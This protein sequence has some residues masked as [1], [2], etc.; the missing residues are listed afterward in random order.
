MLGLQK[1]VSLVLNSVMLNS[2][3]MQHNC[4]ARFKE[5]GWVILA[6]LNGMLG[7]KDEINLVLHSVMVSSRKMCK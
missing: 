5:L 7:L 1:E 4:W 2:R 6:R 3:K